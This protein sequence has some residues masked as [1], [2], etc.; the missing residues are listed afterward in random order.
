MSKTIQERQKKER[1]ALLSHLR[2][3]PIIQLACEKSGVGRATYYR[4]RNEDREFAKEADEALH[5][6]ISLMNDFA[7]SQ[8]IS[9]IKDKNMTAIIYWLKHRHKDYSTRVELTG[10]IKTEL[11]KLTPEQEKLIDKAINLVVGKGQENES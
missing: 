11:G 4:W 1:D 2:K 8:L 5:E 3:T 10:E 6:G 9:S 7:E